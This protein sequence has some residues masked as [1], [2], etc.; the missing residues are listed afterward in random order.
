MKNQ[1]RVDR[2]AGEL[3]D[4][5]EKWRT[6]GS[7][8]PEAVEVLEYAAIVAAEEMARKRAKLI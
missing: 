7:T 5:C 6:T 3:A 8:L 1:K 2:M 4:L